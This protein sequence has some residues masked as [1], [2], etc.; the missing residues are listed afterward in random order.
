MELNFTQT[1]IAFTSHY[2]PGHNS[3]GCERALSLLTRCRYGTLADTTDAVGFFCVGV[4]VVNI[5]YMDYPRMQRCSAILDDV[6]DKIMIK[7]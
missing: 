4:G 6:K 7:N 5:W 2:S 3:Y 1:E